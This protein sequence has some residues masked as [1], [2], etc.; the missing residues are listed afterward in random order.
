MDYI[1]L[2]VKVS[3]NLIVLQWTAGTLNYV[4][5]CNRELCYHIIENC[6]TVRKDEADLHE[7]MPL[8]GE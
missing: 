8:R 3:N 7:L 5:P 4:H 6:A 2:K 1:V